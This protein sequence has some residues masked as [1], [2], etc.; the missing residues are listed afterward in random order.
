VNLAASVVAAQSVADGK[1]PGGL[2]LDYPPGGAGR[3]AILAKRPEI[4]N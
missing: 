1:R 3:R 2:R 4:E